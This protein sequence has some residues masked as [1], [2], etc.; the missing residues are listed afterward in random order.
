VNGSHKHVS[1][2]SSVEPPTSSSTLRP[3]T[4]AIPHTFPFGAA[5][6]CTAPRAITRLNG[7]Q[8]TR[9][10]KSGNN[11]SCRNGYQLA[12]RGPAR[13]NMH[14]NNA[15]CYIDL[16]ASCHSLLSPYLSRREHI[17]D[18]MSCIAPR[19]RRLVLEHR[20]ISNFR[21]IMEI[22]SSLP[23]IMRH[24]KLSDPGGLVVESCRP[25][26]PVLLSRRGKI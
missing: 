12:T 19:K 14:N 25:A 22:S 18:R 2:L 11:V 20:R 4:P 8:C 23:G 1:A 16:L 10:E 5:D 13:Y 9:R 15:Q 21:F 6:G 3:E 24:I 26:V 7:Y 17:Q